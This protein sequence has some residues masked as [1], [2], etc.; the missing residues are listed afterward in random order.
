[1]S[2][3]SLM[4]KSLDNLSSEKF[5]T[6]FIRAGA[7]AGK[8]TMLIKTFFEFVQ[9]YRACTNKFPKIIITTFTRKATQEIKE[10]L[11]VQALA[12]NDAELFQFVNK[13]SYVHISTI[14][15]VLSLLLNRNHDLLGL[16]SLGEF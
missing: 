5:P 10:R 11:L 1:M 16:S 4:N 7:G 15:G 13:K 6:R 14:H 3:P 9:N 2:S 12:F 8:T